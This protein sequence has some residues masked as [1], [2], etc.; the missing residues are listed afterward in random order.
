MGR[1]RTFI[2]RILYVKRVLRCPLLIELDKAPRIKDSAD[3]RELEVLLHMNTGIED[4]TRE[5]TIPGR[6]SGATNRTETK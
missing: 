6:F 4:L 3:F 2:P 5:R 1:S